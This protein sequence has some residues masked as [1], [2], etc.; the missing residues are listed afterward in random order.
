MSKYLPKFMLKWLEGDKSF[1]H[2][3]V[4]D[5]KMSSFRFVKVLSSVHRTSYSSPQGHNIDKLQ[6]AIPA[7]VKRAISLV[8]Q[9][10][11]DS[12]HNLRS[13]LVESRTEINS[14]LRSPGSFPATR[15]L[16]DA[17]NWKQPIPENL[18][19]WG[20][21]HVRW[22]SDHEVLHWLAS[23]YPAF[24]L[25]VLNC[26]PVQGS[27]LDDL[28][29]ALDNVDP[30]LLVYLSKFMAEP[31]KQLL[32]EALTYRELNR[33]G[34][35]LETRMSLAESFSFA[36]SRSDVGDGDIL[37]VERVY[38][39]LAGKICKFNCGDMLLCPGG[40]VSLCG[41]QKTGNNSE[42]RLLRARFIIAL[43]DVA[44]DSDSNRL[45]REMLAQ[46]KERVHRECGNDF[47]GWTSEALEKAFDCLRGEA[48]E[49]AS[50]M[51]QSEKAQED[52][53]KFTYAKYC[54][55]QR[56]GGVD[57]DEGTNDSGSDSDSEEKHNRSTTQT[58]DF[59][60]L[61]QQSLIRKVCYAPPGFLCPV[62]RDSMGENLI[63]AYMGAQDCLKSQMNNKNS[64]P[65]FEMVEKLLREEGESECIKKRT[66]KNSRE[67][68]LRRTFI[69][70]TLVKNIKKFYEQENPRD[71]VLKML[72]GCAKSVLDQ[73]L[74]FS[75]IGNAEMAWISRAHQAMH[76]EGL[77]AQDQ[78]ERLLVDEEM[79]GGVGLEDFDENPDDW[80]CKIKIIRQ[81]ISNVPFIC[82]FSEVFGSCYGILVDHMISGCLCWVRLSKIA[83]VPLGNGPGSRLPSGG[84]AL[85]LRWPQNLS[86]AHAHNMKY[87]DYIFTENF[88]CIRNVLRAE[89]ITISGDSL[90]YEC[91]TAKNAGLRQILKSRSLS[92]KSMRDLIQAE[93]ATQISDNK[94]PKA[95]ATTALATI[96]REQVEEIWEKDQVHGAIVSFLLEYQKWA[97]AE[98]DSGGGDDNGMIGSSHS[99]GSAAVKPEKKADPDPNSKNKDKAA[100][101]PPKFTFKPKSSNPPPL[102]LDP[103]NLENSKEPSGAGHGGTNKRHTLVLSM[104]CSKCK[105]LAWVIETEAAA[106]WGGR[107]IEVRWADLDIFRDRPRGFGSKVCYAYS[108]EEGRETQA[109]SIVQK[110]TS[111]FHSQCEGEVTIT[112]AD[113]GEVV[114]D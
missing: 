65:S 112:V 94:I 34:S 63:P 95:L 39:R 101:A 8:S 73:Q 61:S 59:N 44:D 110:A 10:A 106:G 113:E 83:G 93:C 51:I 62:P 29:G 23:N 11:R 40:V 104:H 4:Q 52:A 38:R 109:R 108:T 31:I 14:E 85:R 15:D 42:E 84:R 7:H 22:G 66:L 54:S 3:I 86:V 96:P 19:Q 74:T 28:L 9:V 49:H 111:R 82:E 114:E 21:G 99:L 80:P 32:T 76:R 69:T 72:Q 53:F 18:L 27:T 25:V 103:L 97:R 12:L 91:S 36:V 26:R 47:R 56:R 35:A 13:V 60:N 88:G 1:N 102:N 67:D 5:R 45:V 89:H 17:A 90:I 107:R 68:T 92:V 50:R 16:I 75:T 78:P 57:E 87:C 100:A 48:L 24:K 58:T 71:P 46:F 43:S 105:R 55:S 41:P 2:Q 37:A 81:S 20:V 70:K 79:G 6:E 33:S 77:A 98:K 30:R 64:F